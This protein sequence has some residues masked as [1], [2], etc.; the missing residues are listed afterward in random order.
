MV[1]FRRFEAKHLISSHFF[2]EAGGRYS[3]I[4]DEA[5]RVLQKSARHQKRHRSSTVVD[6]TL[7]SEEARWILKIQYV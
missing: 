2:R 4:C 6:M 1:I 7:P 5:G 3:Q